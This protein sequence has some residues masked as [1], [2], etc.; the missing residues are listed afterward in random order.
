MSA[1]ERLADLGLTLPA[2]PKPI[3]NDG[4]APIDAPERRRTGVALHHVACPRHRV[5]ADRLQAVLGRIAVADLVGTG[6][7]QSGG[8][9]HRAIRKC[10]QDTHQP[11]YEVWRNQ[12][13]ASL[14]H[15][16]IR[17]AGP[18]STLDVGDGPDVAPVSPDPDTGMAF[19]VVLHHLHCAV[20]RGIV[21]QRQR[22]GRPALRQHA[23]DCRP[24]RIDAVVDHHVDVDAR[25]H[26]CTSPAKRSA[27][28]RRGC[29]R[30][31]VC[32]TADLP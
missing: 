6:E 5:G 20:S 10:Q 1:D 2:P 28:H 27:A 25:Q 19:S 8:V 17:I 15:D 12:V 9:A 26:G 13:I 4:A 32:R 24:D 22:H 31:V 23:V 21:E 14:R 16:K 29:G 11:L 18:E 30:S 7:H 3:G